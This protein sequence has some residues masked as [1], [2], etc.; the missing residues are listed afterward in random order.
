M[1]K[2]HLHGA[3]DIDTIW[4]NFNGRGSASRAVAP[5]VST[6]TLHV[7]FGQGTSFRGSLFF[8]DKFY[9]S[10]AGR[11]VSRGLLSVECY[12]ETV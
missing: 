6:A 11:A 7:A 1:S 4:L 2:C 5:F 12:M 3:L 10:N 9:N 8:F